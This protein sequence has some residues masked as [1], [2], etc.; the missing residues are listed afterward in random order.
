MQYFW[1]ITTCNR[2]SA[3]GHPD[4]L[5]SKLLTI[6]RSFLNNVGHPTTI[7]QYILEYASWMFTVQLN[8][9][10]NKKDKTL[11]TVSRKKESVLIFIF[12]E[13]L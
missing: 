6:R 8:L 5:N 4:V 3:A 11:A 12:F 7:G 2:T 9:H 13:F 10:S 1:Y